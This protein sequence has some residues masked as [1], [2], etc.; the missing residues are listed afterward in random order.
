MSN[1]VITPETSEV[2]CKSS[3][4]QRNGMSILNP[5]SP[6]LLAYTND[7]RKTITEYLNNSRLANAQSSQ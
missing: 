2:I 3:N 6:L 1:A 5:V 4:K 7:S